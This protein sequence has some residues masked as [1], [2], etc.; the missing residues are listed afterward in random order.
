MTTILAQ[1]VNGKLPNMPK[2]LMLL[3]HHWVVGLGVHTSGVLQ[4]LVLAGLQ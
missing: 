3:K 2:S 4:A 1:I